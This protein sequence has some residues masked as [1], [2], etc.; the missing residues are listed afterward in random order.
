[1]VKVKSIVNVVYDFNFS[2]FPFHWVYF[3]WR[4]ETEW[5]KSKQCYFLLL[6]TKSFLLKAYFKLFSASFTFENLP[7]AW[8]EDKKRGFP[9]Q[10]GRQRRSRRGTGRRRPRWPPE[11]IRPSHEF[12]VPGISGDFPRKL[13]WTVG[14]RF[15]SRHHPVIV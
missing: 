12:P 14:P 6:Q 5:E 7:L 11:K 4:R 13:S 15:S 8:Q 10:R 3:I 1:M 9:C 2:S